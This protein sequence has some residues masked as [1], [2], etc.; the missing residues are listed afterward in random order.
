[1][2]G[3]GFEGDDCNHNHNFENG[4]FMC[5]VSSQKG[6]QKIYHV[7]IKIRLPEARLKMERVEVL[8]WIVLRLRELEGS[9]VDGSE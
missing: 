4:L 8:Q 2:G 1:M 7:R 6:Y 3:L 5:A 9:R